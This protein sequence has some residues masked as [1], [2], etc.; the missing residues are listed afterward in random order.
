LKNNGKYVVPITPNHSASAF[1]IP[2][3]LVQKHKLSKSYVEIEEMNGGLFI[4]KAKEQTRTKTFLTG[5]VSCGLTIPSYLAHKYQYSGEGCYA[6]LTEE[7]NGI[8]IKK[9]AI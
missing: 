7:D 1:T 4:K 5:K 6:V 3:K 2:H 8:F 9:L